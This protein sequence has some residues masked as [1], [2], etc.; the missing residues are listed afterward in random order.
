MPGRRQGQG[1]AAPDGSRALIDRELYLPESWA[2]DRE[3]CQEAGIGDGVAFVTKPGLARKMAERAG[4]SMSSAPRVA[5]RSAMKPT[6][7]SRIH[8]GIAQL[9]EAE[10][11]QADQVVTVIRKYRAANLTSRSTT[12]L[13]APSD[14]AARSP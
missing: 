3:R 10:R 12:C 11:A 4:A 6:P 14:P 7:I 5:V 1:R 9:T 13:S 8:G 2:D